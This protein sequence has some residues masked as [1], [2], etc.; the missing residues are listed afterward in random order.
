MRRL[1]AGTSGAVVSP[2]PW[3]DLRE[4]GDQWE[5]VLSALLRGRTLRPVQHAA[6]FEARI[7]E[8][9]QHLVVCAPTN[10]GKSL[11]GALVLVDAVLRHRRAILLEPLRALAQEQAD[12]LQE[13]LAALVPSV[14]MRA[15]RVR[16]STGDYRLEHES[17]DALPPAE[18]EVIVA[19]PE[20]LDAILRNPA[21]ARWIETIGAVVID[22]AHLLADPRRGPTLEMI[23]ASMLSMPASPRLALLSATIGEPEGLRE[24]LRPCQLVTSS[25]RTA[26]RKEVWQLEGAEDPDAILEAELADVL[27]DPGAAAIVFVYRREAADALARR[28]GASLPTGV[29]AYHSGLSASDRQ[30]I[31]A[32]FVEGASRCLV[33]TTA[34]AMGVNLPAT[35]VIVRDTTFFGSGI[36]RTEELLQILGRAGRGDRSGLGVVVVRPSDAWKPDELA[37]ALREEV[38]R[39]LQSSFEARLTRPAGRDA[40][41]PKEPGAPLVAAWLCR[42]G[43]DGLEASAIARLLGN[44]LGARALVGRTDAVLRWLADPSRALAYRNEEG[45]WHLTVLGYAGVRAMLP[46]GY[47]AG[48]GQLIRD[49]LSLDP[50]AVLLQRWSSLDHL[51]VVSLLSERTPG[52]RRFSEELAQQIDGWIEARPANETPI[53]FTQWVVGGA[54]TSRADELLGSLG[55]HDL[56][57]QRSSKGAARRRAYVAMLSAIVLDERARGAALQDLESRWRVTGLSGIEEAWRDTALWHLA[58][59]AAVLDVRTFYHHLRANCEATAEQVGEAKRVLRRMRRQAHDLLDG[60]K[61]CS[62]LG[63]LLR[64][65]RNMVRDETGHALGVGTIRKLENAGIRSIGEVARTDLDA[66]VGSGVQRRFAKQ[67]RRY[68]GRRMR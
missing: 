17:P 57:P 4:F 21:N 43:E 41:T 35:H 38:L 53:L 10:S 28:L 60:L 8:S 66:L 5:R 20:R 37:G 27:S 14:L 59:H 63:P 25:A 64:G 22:E 50:S 33:A 48:L 1:E 24:W 67:I 46:L 18:G 44:T 6:L 26:L 3:S 30:R 54:E 31:R 7:L 34:L 19:T 13:L 16:L 45:Q 65:V 56:R 9:R 29:H 12:G 40:D 42:A 58:G 11:V 62:P 39:P 55:L 49:L 51:Y 47:T 15:P 36:L 23:G 52:L 68:I 2:A 32:Q 61:Y